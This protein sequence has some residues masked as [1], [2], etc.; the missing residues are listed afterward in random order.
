MP[1]VPKADVLKRIAEMRRVGRLNEAERLCRMEMT[2][3]RSNAALILA[4]GQI[5]VDRGRFEEAMDWYRQAERAGLASAE[6]YASIGLA[7]HALGERDN[8]RR[9]LRHAIEIDPNE[10]EFWTRLGFVLSEQGQHLEAGLL[11]RERAVRQPHEINDYNFGQ[12]LVAANRFVSAAPVFR[13]GIERNGAFVPLHVAL[14]K[15]LA[16]VGKRAEAAES[17]RRAL[18]LDPGASEARLALEDL[19]GDA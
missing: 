6:L 16:A 17:L 14:G 3:Q 5:L 19:G 13:K 18:E 4:L 10:M 2:L 8:A 9:E 11:M 12:E 15:A 7:Y 1:P